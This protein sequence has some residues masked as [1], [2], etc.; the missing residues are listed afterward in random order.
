MLLPDRYLKQQ[1]EFI[2]KTGVVMGSLVKLSD[3]DNNWDEQCIEEEFGWDIGYVTDD[4]NDGEIREV[5]SITQREGFEVDRTWYP[6]CVIDPVRPG[7]NLIT[8]QSY[9]PE[10]YKKS[11]IT[12]KDLGLLNEIMR[13]YPYNFWDIWFSVKDK[14]YV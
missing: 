4:I 11:G 5:N 14:E 9:Y 7:T 13:I 6:W 10:I 8:L 12:G 1:Y 2:K 3:F